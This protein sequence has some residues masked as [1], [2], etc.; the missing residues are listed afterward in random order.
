MKELIKDALESAWAD[1]RDID[2][3]SD[4]PADLRPAIVSAWRVTASPIDINEAFLAGEDDSD[5]ATLLAFALDE[6]L[7]HEGVKAMLNCF[8]AGIAWRVD[9]AILEVRAEHE[10]TALIAKEERAE[11]QAEWQRERY[12]DAKEYQA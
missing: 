9:A 1:G 3:A 6:T 10:L 2:D 12:A 7:K 11:Q 4:I 8:W 5:M